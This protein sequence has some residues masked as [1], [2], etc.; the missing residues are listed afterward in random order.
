M[1]DLVEQEL[2]RVVSCHVGAEN[3]TLGT[4]E[5]QSVL[6]TAEPSLQPH[7]YF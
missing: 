1:L 4:L 2:Q 5:E 3:W 6:L 7:K